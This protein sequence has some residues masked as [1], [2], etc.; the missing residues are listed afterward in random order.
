LSYTRGFPA[1]KPADLRALLDVQ[2]DLFDEAIPAPALR[3]ELKA[4]LTP[5]QQALLTEAQAQQ[6]FAAD[7]QVE[8]GGNDKDHA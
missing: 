1:E 6:R 3:P 5:L 4:K 2:R 7:L 8:E